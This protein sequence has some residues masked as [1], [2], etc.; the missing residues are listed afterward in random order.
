MNK[1][2][3]NKAKSCK[4]KEELLKL[5]KENNFELSPEEAELYL[6]EFIEGEI[7]DTELD[8]VAGG[9][10]G[11]SRNPYELV[12][13]N[14]EE[15]VQYIF[16]VGEIKQCFVDSLGH[17]TRTVRIIDRKPSQYKFDHSKWIDEYHIKKIS[18]WGSDD[19][20]VKRSNF[21]K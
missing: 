14:S 6:Q 21:E 11:C 10:E 16:E 13:Y 8:N 20:W 15:E 9:T 2:L 1:E 5:A 18:G 12:I 3:I 7:V 19:E 17:C 4:T